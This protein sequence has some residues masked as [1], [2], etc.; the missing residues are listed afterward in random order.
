MLD[1]YSHVF[2]VENKTSTCFRGNINE[3]L[4]KCVLISFNKI[5]SSK[6]LTF[7][8][9]IWVFDQGPLAS[10]VNANRRELLQKLK[11]LLWGTGLLLE[12]PKFSPAKTL[13]DC[14]G[15]K[16]KPATGMQEEKPEYISEDNS[17]ICFWSKHARRVE[18]LVCV[19]LHRSEANTRQRPPISSLPCD[20]LRFP[21]FQA[22]L[23][24]L[25]LFA[26]NIMFLFSCLI[27]YGFLCC[28]VDF[29]PLW[30][31]P[32]VR[33]DFHSQC[34]WRHSELLKIFMALW[35]LFSPLWQFNFG[36][37]VGQDQDVQGVVDNEVGILYGW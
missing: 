36:Q 19:H 32:A 14:P 8:F 25:N 34:H 20:R 11:L 1:W 18:G 17:C 13:H 10:L 4:L 15:L 28:V 2:S 3:I 30:S 37:W 6:G 31:C 27:K 35:V 7:F 23:F 16:V 26:P 21:L 33:F 24:F 29:S 12:R 22:F 9:E 5:T